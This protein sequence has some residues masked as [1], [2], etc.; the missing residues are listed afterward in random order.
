MSVN[1]FFTTLFV[2]RRFRTISGNREALQATA[3]VDLHVQ[4]L[5]RE[6]RTRLGISEERIWVGYFDAEGFDI[7]AE[8]VLYNA[9]GR[10]YKVIEV[11][12]KTYSFGINQH[13]EVLLAEYNV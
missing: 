4:S 2:V 10:A 7:E 6:A 1:R 9:D 3:T 13:R 11:I 12:D 8:D 5:D